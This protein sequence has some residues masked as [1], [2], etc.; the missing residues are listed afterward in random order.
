VVRWAGH[1]YYRE[2]LEAGVRI[3]EYQRTMIHSKTLVVDGSWSVVGSA[4][5]DIRSKE[6]NQES[7]IGILDRGFGEQLE[8][9]FEEDLRESREI[10]RDFW[11]RRGPFPRFRA[12]F[13][14]TFAEQL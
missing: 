2:M 10:T 12:A 6:L 1:A 11:H 13:W 9:T 7:V 3:F 8:A 14:E 4:N 5:M